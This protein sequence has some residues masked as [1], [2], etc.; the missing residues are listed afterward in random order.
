MKNKNI[1]LKKNKGLLIKKTNKKFNFVLSNINLENLNKD[2][3]IIKVLY[4]CFNFKD[5]LMAKGNPGLVRNYP[6]VPGID[7]TGKVYYSNS[8]KFKKGDNVMVIARPTGINSFGT[9]SNYFVC[10]SKWIEKIPFKMNMKTPI[11]FG[12]AGFTAMLA[13]QNIINNKVK[14][15]F[16]ILVTGAS[17]GVGLM[18]IF[19]LNN[20][21]YKIIASTTGVKKNL[22]L[23]KKIGVTS[24][25]D[26]KQFNK[27][28]DLP[29]LKMKYSAIIDN[30]GGDVVSFGSRELIQNGILISVG[31]V[32]SNYSKI[33]IL[34]FIL[35]GVKLI[36][37]NSESVSSALRKKIWKSIYKNTKNKKLNLLYRKYD[38][39]MVIKIFSKML[40][41]NYRGR[42][43]FKI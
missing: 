42:V 26:H 10:P 21:G 24:V 18:S 15:N 9:M 38:F 25:I 22:N 13:V 41:N 29:I 31:N 4:S 36:G 30:V 39:N 16:P 14:K 40:K 34:P 1:L 35:R 33:N 37:I 23:L 8:K 28:I 3:V 7:C 6:H 11:I 12:T 17:G 32:H 20:L 5:I 27:S 2:E 19:F 43:I